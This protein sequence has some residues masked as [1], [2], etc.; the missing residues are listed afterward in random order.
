MFD[1]LNDKDLEKEIKGLKIHKN[2][3]RIKL[4]E[5]Y[6]QLFRYGEIFKM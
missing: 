4:K 6:T 1:H 3:A 5:L 2:Q